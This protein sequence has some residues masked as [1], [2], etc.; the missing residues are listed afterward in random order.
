LQ[1]NKV[2]TASSP[3]KNDTGLALGLFLIAV[4]VS[5]LVAA[6]GTGLKIGEPLKAGAP[7]IFFGLY[8]MS[9]GLLFLASVVS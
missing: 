9:I 7:T 8:I 1:N 6:F 2:P 4:V 5:L 3:P